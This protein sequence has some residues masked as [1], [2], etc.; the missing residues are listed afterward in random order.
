MKNDTGDGILFAL[1]VV[2]AVLLFYLF[3]PEP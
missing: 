3:M 1:G 2:I